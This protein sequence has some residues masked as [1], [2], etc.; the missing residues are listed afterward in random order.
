MA[1]V[2]RIR[3]IDLNPK[4]IIIKGKMYLAIPFADFLICGCTT[5]DRSLAIV[6]WNDGDIPR[7]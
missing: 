7:P 2:P 3:P 1:Q 4:Y 5:S 6:S